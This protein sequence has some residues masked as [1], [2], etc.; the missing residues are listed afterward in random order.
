MC[1]N[2][3]QLQEAEQR[4][5]C[6]GEGK[7]VCRLA[8]GTVDTMGLYCNFEPVVQ[9]CLSAN[10]DPGRT[11]MCVFSLTAE[12]M[13]SDEVMFVSGTNVFSSISALVI[14]IRRIAAL[15]FCIAGVVLMIVGTA[16]VFK[17]RRH[18]SRSD[19]EIEHPQAH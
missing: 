10:E 12:T 15:V 11:G 5:N 18:R 4:T 6:R 1:T 3:Q 16:L 2:Q 9:G 17:V 7:I 13:G 8:I 14:E 19:Q